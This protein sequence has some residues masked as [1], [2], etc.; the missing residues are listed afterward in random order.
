MFDTEEDLLEWCRAARLDEDAVK[1]I[2][3]IRESE[4]ARVTR[5]R[6]KNVRGR[7]PSR[8]MGSTIQFETHRNMLAFILEMEHDP[9]IIEYWD[10]PPQIKLTYATKAGGN[11]GIIHVPNFFVIRS[12]SAGWVEC[13]EEEKLVKLAV[14]QPERYRRDVDGNWSSPPGEEYG[15]PYRLGYT[16]RSTAE[17]DWMFQRNLLFLED[18]LRAEDLEIPV[19]VTTYVHS[20]VAARPGMPLAALLKIFDKHDLP[21]DII[22]KM[23]VT[24]LL[25]VD[26]SV[27]ALAQP[28]KAFLFYNRDAALLYGADGNPP[29]RPMRPLL[30]LLPSKHIQW[31]G[32]SLEVLNRGEKYTWLRDADG[33]VIKLNNLALE[34]LIEQD[35]IGQVNDDSDQSD[36]E[37]Q[38][39]I[40]RLAT[41]TKA[42]LA[43]ANRRYALL[44][45]FESTGKLQTS[46]ISLRT[47]FYWKSRRRAAEEHFGSGFLGLLPGVHLRGNRN[48]KLPE[49]TI[50]LMD[51]HISAMYEDL[52]QPTRYA[53]WSQLGKVCKERDVIAPS[54]PSFCLR[55]RNRPTHQVESK[56][57]GRRAA[58]STEPL[59]LELNRTT[60]VHGDR[61]FEIGH[62]DHTE[63]EIELLCTQTGENLGRPWLTLLID[64][65]SR[66][67][68]AFFLSFD[69]PSYRSCMMVLRECVRR[70]MRLP[71]ML[72][73]DGG[74][75]FS[76][77]YFETLIAYYE[78]TPK[79]RPPSK[80]RFGSVCERIF[81]TNNTQFIYN[82]AGNTQLTKKNVRLVT[83]EVNPKNLALWTLPDLHE[84]MT[85]YVDE[86]YSAMHHPALSQSPRDAFLAGLAR[87]GHR[88][89][90]RV[91]YNEEF[92][93]LTLP[94]TAKGTAKIVP[95]RGVKINYI[96]YWCEGFRDGAL[97]GT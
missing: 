69:K 93:M 92:R 43:E 31:D 24:N 27:C 76:G 95:G 5:S 55:V 75:E 72:I 73:L 39:V 22:Y 50:K 35:A 9:D 3:R 10:Y 17:I 79:F 46:R 87:G 80:G 44:M 28:D 21:S 54:Y 62:I 42:E 61:P 67:I 45:E 81:G 15:F 84:L 63:L 66:L 18:Y 26:L 51:E 40:E 82:L 56:R 57:K 48:P 37:L 58:Y 23:L 49:E 78:L 41:A 12:N 86:T 8:K 4:P 77:D 52:N 59:Y 60:P 34:R 90:R 74:R 68:L 16:V 38:S 29:T 85:E 65:F 71:Q 32:K 96:F 7:Y 97:E 33:A 6:S 64:A 47:L 94:T 91:Y 13:N 89:H 83:K 14:S 1:I 11:R 25:Y 20:V 19:E 53:V 2:R 36:A 30:S 88:E 70:H